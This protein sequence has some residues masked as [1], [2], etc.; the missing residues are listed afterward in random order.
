MMDDLNPLRIKMMQ[1]FNWNRVGT[2]YYQDDTSTSVCNFIFLSQSV[3]LLIIPIMTPL[4]FSE[5]T[6][7]TILVQLHV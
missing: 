6:P 7:V 1:Y 2:I 5:I 3:N 4:L